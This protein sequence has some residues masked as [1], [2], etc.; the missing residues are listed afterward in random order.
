MAA[1]SYALT[2]IVMGLCMWKVMRRSSKCADFSCT[3]YFIH[4]IVCWLY[5]K[6]SLGFPTSIPFWF[7]MGTSGVTTAVIAE[8]LCMREELEEIPLTQF[9]G[10]TSETKQQQQGTDITIKVMK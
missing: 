4:V 9:V 7:C 8:R 1:S 10:K 6:D 5:N 2:S 3:M